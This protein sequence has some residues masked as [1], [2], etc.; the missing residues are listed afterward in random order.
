MIA[1]THSGMNNNAKKSLWRGRSGGYKGIKIKTTKMMAWMM[2]YIFK[3]DDIYRVIAV[4]VKRNTPYTIISPTI[5]QRLGSLAS[6]ASNHP[7]PAVATNISTL[8]T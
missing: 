3:Y 1:C 4:S 6:N 2:K 7:R 8:I 5:N